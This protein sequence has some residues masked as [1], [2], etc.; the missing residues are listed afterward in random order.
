[1]RAC[2]P[3]GRRRVVERAGVGARSDG[4]CGNGVTKGVINQVVRAEDGTVEGQDLDTA[5]DLVI[6][7]SPLHEAHIVGLKGGGREE[8]LLRVSRDVNHAEGA[9]GLTRGANEAN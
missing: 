1:M 2:P 3:S 8:A 9:R 7:G 6:E 4:A 5:P